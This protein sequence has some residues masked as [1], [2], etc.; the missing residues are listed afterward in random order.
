MSKYLLMAAAALLAGFIALPSPA[1]AGG[2]FLYGGQFHV[3]N[4]AGDGVLTGSDQSA[5][6]SGSSPA[7]ATATA[8]GAPAWPEYQGWMIDAGLSCWCPPWTFNVGGFYT[9]SPNFFSTLVNNGND[10]AT[11]A[12]GGTEVQPT[13]WGLALPGVTDPKPTWFAGPVGASRYGPEILGGGVLG[14]DPWVQRGFANGRFNYT[15]CNALGTENYQNSSDIWAITAGTSWQIRPGTTLSTSYWYWG[16]SSPSPVGFSTN[17]IKA[18]G[19]TINPATGAITFANPGALQ[20]DMFG[21]IG[22]EVDFYIDQQI[23]DNLTLTFVA[24]YL[25]AGDAFCLAP[26]GSNTNGAGSNQ[27]YPGNCASPAATD[28]FKLGARLQWNF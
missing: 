28:A 11:N 26:V 7:G 5:I 24:A 14:G 19:Q 6:S 22:H 18:A 3:L 4:N 1:P 21:S 12:T 13:A 17:S 8:S 16:R 2:E 9:A 27:G 23:F 15:G 20:H 10:A 25:F